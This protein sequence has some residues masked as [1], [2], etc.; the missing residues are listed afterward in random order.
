M[1]GCYSFWDSEVFC[2]VLTYVLAP[3]VVLPSCFG[4]SGRRN[5]VRWSSVAVNPATNK[6]RAGAGSLAYVDNNG[7]G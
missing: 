1:E 2:P 6:R 3:F 4:P 5:G 7:G